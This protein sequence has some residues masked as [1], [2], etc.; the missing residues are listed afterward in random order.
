MT[1]F[2]PIQSF[3]SQ[4]FIE[5]RETNDQGVGV[6]TYKCMEFPY[7]P[8]HDGKGQGTPFFPHWPA[9]SRKGTL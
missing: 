9:E 6:T 4:Y 7:N 8:S 1:T 5:E 3:R 2:Q